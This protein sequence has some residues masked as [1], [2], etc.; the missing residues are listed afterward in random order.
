MLYPEKTANISRR[1]R[2]NAP[3]VTSVSIY[4][5]SLMAAN[6]MLGLR[7][8]KGVPGTLMPILTF[9]R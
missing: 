3:L 6:V 8:G 9:C 5:P 1:G 2:G 4:M 7:R